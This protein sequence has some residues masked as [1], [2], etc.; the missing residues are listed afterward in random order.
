MLEEKGGTFAVIEKV[1]TVK[2]ARTCLFDPYGDRLYVVFPK[3]ESEGP[4]IRIY[5]PL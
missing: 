3:A 5:Q 2:L 1:P 4:M